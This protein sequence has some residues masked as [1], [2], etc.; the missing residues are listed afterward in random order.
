MRTKTQKSVVLALLSMLV[1]LSVLL[2]GCAAITGEAPQV[3]TQI[4]KDITVQDA[5]ALIQGNRGNPGFVIID[6]RTQEE[7]ASGHI[8]DSVNLDYN[9]ETFRDEVGELE[10]SRKYLVYCRTG[11]RSAG[12]VNVMKELGFREVYNMTGGIVQWEADGLPVVK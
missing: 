10:R 8:A 5:H 2:G 4:I 6:V 7:Y 11:R 12:A 9:S 1:G 3:E